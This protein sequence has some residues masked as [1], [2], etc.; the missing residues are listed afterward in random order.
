VPEPTALVVL[1]E[2]A[3]FKRSQDGVNL[4]LAVKAVHFTAASCLQHSAL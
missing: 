4:R 3:W 1:R 2:V